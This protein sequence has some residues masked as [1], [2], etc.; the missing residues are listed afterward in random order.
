MT[1][2]GSGVIGDSLPA[3]EQRAFAILAAGAKPHADD[4][5][6][7]Q[8]ATG[9][10]QQPLHVRCKLAQLQQRRTGLVLYL[11]PA[12]G[13]RNS[14]CQKQRQAKNAQSAPV[15]HG[16]ASPPYTHCSESCHSRSAAA[17]STA[18]GCTPPELSADAASA[19]WQSSR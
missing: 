18:Q 5:G 12:V 6:K 19:T 14:G 4:I 1:G 9:T 2:S 3:H 11:F 13:A 7:H 10:A 15:T 17:G 16:Y 8:H